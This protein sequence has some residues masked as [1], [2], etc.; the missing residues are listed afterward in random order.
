MQPEVISLGEPMLEF[1][2]LTKGSLRD[3]D[4]FKRSWGGD[5]SNFAVAVARLERKAGYVCRV[6]DDDF[7][8]CFLD[9]WRR[10]GVDTSHVIVEKGGFTGIYFISIID[11]GEHDFTYYR[12]N[13][14]ASHLCQEDIDA[15]YIEQAEVFHTSGISQA[16]SQSC[17]EAVFTAIEI[18]KRSGVTFSYDPNVRLKLWPIHTARA[19]IMRTIELADIVMPSLEDVKILLGLDS[20][21]Q[22]ADLIMKRGPKM[23][24]IKLGSEGS[25]VAY[26]DKRIRIP[27]FKVK[28][29]DTTGA[30]D[31]FNAAFIVSLL[32]GCDPVESAKFANAVGALTTLGKGAVEPIPKRGEVYEFLK[33]S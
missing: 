26:D 21:E 30:G 18:A 7:G 29:V 23:V 17:R 2:A 16:I 32:E 31:A 1:N 14:S 15:S 28:P 24:V 22:A 12:A 4:I 20:P 9:F 3:V 10:E 6:G 25:L 19:V 27:G 11:G 33:S 8:R 13:S 5:T